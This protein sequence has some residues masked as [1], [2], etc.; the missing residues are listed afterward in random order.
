MTIII[1]TLA[2]TSKDLPSFGVFKEDIVQLIMSTDPG[3]SHQSLLLGS[4][5]NTL[6]GDLEIAG[7]IKLI[8][9]ITLF[10]RALLDS[11]GYKLNGIRHER[12]DL[13]IPFLSYQ[14]ILADRDLALKNMH[15]I[16]PAKV[17]AKLRFQGTTYKSDIR[18]K[19]DAQDHWTSQYRMS[20]RISLKGDRTLLGFKE[21]SL[22][23]PT[24]RQFPYDYSYQSTLSALGNITS[25]HKFVH[26]YVNGRSWGIMNLEEHMTKE[27]LEKQKR[28]ESIIIKFGDE[29][30]WAYNTQAADPYPYYILANGAFTVNV[31]QGGEY[32]G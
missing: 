11:I 14:S 13:D 5:P 21:F 16:N 24:S 9:Y 19:G 22:Q 30:K 27:F 4:D 23:K 28:K 12:L 6:K 3:F 26:L 18:L 29:T 10:P 32:L 8:Q 2:F 31:F 1:L 15:S 25:A 7:N 17:K 20:L